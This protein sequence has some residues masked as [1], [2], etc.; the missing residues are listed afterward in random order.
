MKLLK[1]AGLLAAVTPVISTSVAATHPAWWDYRSVLSAGAAKDYAAA[2]QGQVKQIALMT[3]QEFETRLPGGAGPALTAL[4]ASWQQP[5]AAGVVRKDY[6]AI[7]QGQLKSIA[8][9][10]Y[11]RLAEIGYHGAPLPAGRTYPWTATT[12]DDQSYAGANLGQVKYLF[13][14]DLNA[15]LATVDDTDGNGLSDAWERAYFTHIGV[16]PYDDPDNDGLNNL[17]EYL[18]GTNP[19]SIDTDG[20]GMNDGAEIKAL[21][22][23]GSDKDKYTM[24]SG[25]DVMIVLPADNYYGFKKNDRTLT[26]V[27]A[28]SSP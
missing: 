21:R 6:A 24:P 5:P 7:N 2:N 22:D 15:F 19:K 20:D 25:Y 10:F 17:Q 4:I 16:N 18:R 11:D 28:T 26:K 8:K 13:A 1:M 12:A 23:P 3:F 9:L 27:S 14:I